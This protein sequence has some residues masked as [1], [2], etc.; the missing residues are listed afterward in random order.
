[1]WSAWWGLDNA[2]SFDGEL[3]DSYNADFLEFWNA[4]LAHKPV[5]LIDL[6]CGNGGITWLADSICNGSDPTTQITGFDFTDIKPF[7][8]MNRKRENFPS[9]NFIG[10]TSVENLPMDD[11][12][13]DMVISQFGIEYANLDQVIPEISRVLKDN[14]RIAFIMHCDWSVLA[15]DCLATTRRYEYLLGEG[16][17][18]EI[19]F[20]LD[21]LYNSKRSYPAV[22]GDPIFNTLNYRLNTTVYQAKN[23]SFEGKVLA[24]SSSVLEYIERLTGLFSPKKFKN[25]ARKN[26]IDEGRR[27]VVQT[28][29]RQNDLLNAAL[30]EDRRKNFLLLLDQEGFK[31]HCCEDFYY[32]GSLYGIRITADRVD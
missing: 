17:F 4:A 24:E 8:R 23:L 1:M 2:T 16:Q 29:D 3:A 14:A 15:I 6:C 10:N 26:V 32:N 27:N 13:V 31:N 18:H 5:H 7:K 20:E 19:L 22:E 28:C 9:V 12:S 25:R 30:T 21:E 11:K